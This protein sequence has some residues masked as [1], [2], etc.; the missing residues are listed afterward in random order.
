MAVARRANRRRY[1]LVVI[2]M[3]ALTL[4]TLDTRNGRS[5]PIGVLGSAAHAIVGPVQNTVDD[6][7]S[8]VSDWWSGV[9]D[10]GDIK[11]ENR[12]LHDRVSTLE[13]KDRAAQA[14]LDENTSLRKQ[15][16][17]NGL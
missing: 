11:A 16:G 7:V 4:I 17:L 15:L 6:V 9:T 14:A 3:T 1:V 10:A 12:K 2:V 8:P 13:G 5:G